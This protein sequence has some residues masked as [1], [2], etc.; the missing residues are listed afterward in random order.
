M[1]RIKN[2]GIFFEILFINSLTTGSARSIR[3]GA[4]N[5]IL[6]QIKVFGRNIKTTLARNFMKVPARHSFTLL[7]VTRRIIGVH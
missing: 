7:R 2:V 4:G 6:F 5:M 3:F 1:N